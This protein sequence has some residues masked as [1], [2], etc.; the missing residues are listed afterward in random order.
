M[1]SPLLW[2]WSSW[3]ILLVGVFGVPVLALLGSPRPNEH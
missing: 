1:I 2:S 3:L